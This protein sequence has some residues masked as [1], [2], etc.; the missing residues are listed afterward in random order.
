MNLVFGSK[1]YKSVPLVPQRLKQKVLGLYHASEKK[2][3]FDNRKQRLTAA[4]SSMAGGKFSQKEL[5]TSNW[6]E[7]RDFKSDSRMACTLFSCLAEFILLRMPRLCPCCEKDSVTDSFPDI[8]IG[9]KTSSR[10][11]S[12][13]LDEV[14]AWEEG[15]PTSRQ[16]RTYSNNMKHDKQELSWAI[17]AHLTFNQ[18]GTLAGRLS[19]CNIQRQ[20]HTHTV[21]IN[22]VHELIGSGWFG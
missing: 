16:S 15:A 19:I 3:T 6:T 7:T 8:E 4:I 1:T 18:S 5:I 11:P 17:V 12:A 2:Q 13:E 9:G 10:P 21:P 22:F 14:E 20:H